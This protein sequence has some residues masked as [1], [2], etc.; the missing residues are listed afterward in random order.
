MKKLC[1]TGYPLHS[2]LPITVTILLNKDCRLR[3]P[4]NATNRDTAFVFALSILRFSMMTARCF[5]TVT[6]IDVLRHL[7]IQR[8]IHCGYCSNRT[9][10]IIKKVLSWNIPFPKQVCCCGLQIYTHNT[11]I[12]RFFINRKLLI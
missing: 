11:K 4:G 9:I 7:D 10:N 6:A 2:R 1:M 8:R 5:G 12:K 3:Y